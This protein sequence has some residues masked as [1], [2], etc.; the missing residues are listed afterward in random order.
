MLWL[1]EMNI[2]AI[3]AQQQRVLGEQL[4]EYDKYDNIA[5]PSVPSKPADEKSV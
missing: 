3:L 4:V 1:L 2:P 5:V